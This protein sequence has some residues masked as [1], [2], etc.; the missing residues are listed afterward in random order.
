MELLDALG[1]AVWG[2]PMMLLLLGAGLYLSICTGFPQIVHFPRAI[3]YTFG[4]IRRPRDQAEGV[5]PFRAA[6]TA[7]AGAVGTGNIAGV[8]GAVSLGGPGAVFWMWASAVLGMCTKYCE[9]ALAVRFRRRGRDGEWRGGPMIYIRDGLGPRFAPLA[10]LFSLFGMLASFGIGCTAQ[11][12]TVAETVA[13][14][15]AVFFPLTPGRKALLLWSVSVLCAAAAGAVILGGA[16]RLAE[17]TSRI[18]PV[19][20]LLYLAAALAVILLRAEALPRVLRAIFHGAFDPAA[21]TGGAAGIGLRQAVRKGISRGIFSNEAG[22]GSSPIAHACSAA[23]HPAEQ[24]LL[25]IFEVF[26]DTMVICTATAL[27]ILLGLGER[28]IPYGTD[29]GAALTVRGFQAV[30]GGRGP[31]LL[32]AAVL[33]LFAL[34]TLLTWSFY[35]SRCAEYLLGTRG[36]KLYQLLF[37]LAA[38][39]SGGI[40]L[41]AVWAVSELCNGLM[42][43]PNLIGVLA[44]SPA[45]A[46][47]TR[48]YFKKRG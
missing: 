16:E 13:G 38:A 30:L 40:R 39:I 6:C 22:M 18:V 25:G 8:A 43:I 2:A 36:A 11:V 14:A 10:G 29:P 3:R 12:N 7:L 17:V 45:A 42:A 35:G 34:S 46:R 48:D 4:S 24:G 41:E 19:M 47:L 23:K 33:A 26:A 37:C 31:A 21:V 15:A 20:A 9:A 5:S 44:L 32:A 27:V 28:R 1:R